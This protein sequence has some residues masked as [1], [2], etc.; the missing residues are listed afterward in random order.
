MTNFTTRL[1]VAAATLVAAAGAASA[2]TM[3][4]EI[5]F[6][7]RANGKVMTAGTYEVTLSH[8]MPLLYLRSNDGNHAAIVAAQA[9]HDA[10]KPWRAAGGPVLSFECGNSLC[11]LAGVWSGG[12]KPAYNF[13]KPKLGKDEPTRMALVA[14]LPEKGD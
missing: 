8:G 10:P 11:S 13:A 2:Q 1:M 5:P 3:K 7:F 12:D 4:A 9:P 14:L 6:T